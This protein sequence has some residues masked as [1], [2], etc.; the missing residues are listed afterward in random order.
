MRIRSKLAIALLVPLVALAALAWVSIGAANESADEAAERAQITTDQVELGTA[1][2]GPAG[3]ITAIQNERNLT[4]AEAS[5]FGS[6]MGEDQSMAIAREDTD[7]ALADFE[8]IIG[9][10]DEAVRTAYEP[11]FEALASLTAIRESVDSY[12][13]PADQKAAG[14]AQS[15]FFDGF[16]KILNTV[17]DVNSGI[18]VGL[19]DPELRG[20]AH[21]VNQMGRAEDLQAV[22]M[23]YAALPVMTGY[24]NLTNDTVSFAE[25]GRL[26]GQLRTIERDI[27]SSG[28]VAYQ[29][30]GKAMFADPRLD[31]TTGIVEVAMSGQ[32]VDVAQFVTP[33]AIAW[34][35]V[36]DE[37]RNTA[38]A[39]L[40]A[41]A[42]ELITDARAEQDDAE[43]RARLILIAAIAA[44]AIGLAIALAAAR[45]IA[46]P[47]R[48]LVGD[49]EKMAGT[50]LPHAVQSILDAPLGDDVV[51]PE[52]EQVSPAGGAEI[53]EVAAA[54]NTVQDSA[55]NLAIE[56][57]VLRRN[58][59]DSFVNLGRR[60]QNLLGRQ[61]DSITEMEREETD[62]ESLQKLF[63]LDH[64]ATRMRRN[65]ESLLL[66][67]GL[68]PHRQWSAPVSLI[69]VIRGAL[70]EVEQYARVEI[71]RFDDAVVNGSTAAD[72]THLV[73]ELL[74]N[75][76]TF[77]PPGHNVRISG[78]AR[79]KGYTLAIIDNGMGMKPE[80]LE[81]AN[82]RLSGGESFTVAPSRYLGHYVVGIQAARL[83]T[84][85][86]LQHTPTG[87]VTAMI[88]ITAALA[89]DQPAVEEA[90][91]EALS[92]GSLVEGPDAGSDGATAPI[93]VPADQLGASAV[94]FGDDIEA[95]FAELL[96]EDETVARP[97]A[98]PVAAAPV[99]PDSMVRVDGRAPSS[100]NGSA[101]GSGEGQAWP[102]AEASP[103]AVPEPIAY[104]STAAD[105]PAG[106]TTPSGYRKRVRGTH[107]PR[108][109]VVLARGEQ[110][111]QPTADS[112]DEDSSADRMRS[113]LSGL[114]AGSDRAQA[115][116][117]RS[118]SDNTEDPR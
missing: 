85:V 3:V 90:S 96:A 87:G 12:V 64:L 41:H 52:L 40:A 21:F 24:S 28:P 16:T 100:A 83:G 61:L 84:P 8:R 60:N 49:A 33:E 46:Q 58:I 19:D 11:A 67:A 15:E 75:A 56:Q 68:E 65:A 36:Y 4:V 18:V 48:R 23:R 79:E 98:A 89:T 53:A 45:S 104:E 77:S 32:A 81:Q 112:A 73:A 80:A 103:A 26:Q 50:N 113:M 101:N 71:A 107:T 39:E 47:L 30:L 110:G 78:A 57:A 76:L 22:L 93:D 97:A 37:Y 20:G 109:D 105:A 25:A 91:G 13:Q 66:L 59:S 92:A 88:D 54:L 70:G 17:F 29:E 74:E 42:D 55:A 102:P 82:V 108:T 10:S 94:P 27:T 51:M 115:E 114:K 34:S 6:I 63:T 62:P 31:T 111:G 2:I 44:M 95:E 69:D 99:D 5:G 43:G 38:S 9:A 7:Q 118:K 1:T 14:A 116:V 117:G 35:D 106:D 72:L 86:V